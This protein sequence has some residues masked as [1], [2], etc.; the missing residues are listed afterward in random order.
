MCRPAA[1]PAGALPHAGTPVTPVTHVSVKLLPPVSTFCGECTCAA[2]LAVVASIATRA[3]TGCLARMGTAP[4]RRVARS[5]TEQGSYHFGLHMYLF[6][7]P[8]PHLL[9]RQIAQLENCR[10]WRTARP[11]GCGA[12]RRSGRLWMC[13]WS[14]ATRERRASRCRPRVAGLPQPLQSSCSLTD[15]YTL[16]SEQRALHS[17]FSFSQAPVVFGG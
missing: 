9:T 16:S 4:C 10:L 14:C 15:S 12:N 11:V 3:L 6:C 5:S 17:H 7:T 8:S 2:L 1:A 13:L